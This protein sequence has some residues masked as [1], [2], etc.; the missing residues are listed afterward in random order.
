VAIDVA[1]SSLTGSSGGIEGD[2][3]LARMAGTGQSALL[4][5]NLTETAQNYAGGLFGSFIIF[6]LG[7]YWILRSNSRELS[8]IFILI[9]LVMA[10][11]PLIFGDGV[12]QSRMLYDI[13]FQIPAAIGLTYLKR[14]TNGM[15]LILP[16]CI[17]ILA[18][19]IREVSN[20]YFI[21]PS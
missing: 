6:A 7:V 8:S 19:S 17:W 15:L 20:F 2:I 11:L 1:R 14:R 13:P 9:F 18:M 3:G 10:V 5:T 21:S 4:W 16:I 12:I